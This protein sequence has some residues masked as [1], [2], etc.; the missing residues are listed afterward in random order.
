VESLAA[1]GDER[2]ASGWALFTFGDFRLIDPQKLRLVLPNRKVE[3]LLAVLAL[4]RKYGIERDAAAEIVWPGRPRENQRA[5]LRQALSQVRRV[6][7]EDAVEASRSHLRLANSFSLTCDYESPAFRSA[8]AFM[9]GHEGDWFED[10]RREA[11][12][13][14]DCVEAAPS[15]VMGNFMDS[16]GM[17]AEMDPRGMF[18]FMRA[19]PSMSRGV[20][21]SAL[22]RLLFGRLVGEDYDG[23]RDYWFG[24][25]TDDLNASGALLRSAMRKA[26][27]VS[28]Y[29]LASEA[30]LELGRVYSRTGNLERA[31]K[32]CG[33]AETVAELAKTRTAR[34]N[35]LRLRGTHLIN[36]TDSEQG[37]RLLERSEELTDDL[38]GRTHLRSV[39]SFMLASVG[40]LRQAEDL[41]AA[42][43]KMEAKLGHGSTAI[44]VGLTHSLL[45]VAG[46]SP[47][48]AVSGL[49]AIVRRSYEAEIT[50]TGVYA[51]E[52]LAN[53]FNISGDKALAR[54]RL[55]SA[56]QHRSKA[57]MILT[58]V[59]AKRLFYLR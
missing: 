51:E 14:S 49:E 42:P 22:R 21:Y 40:Q 46:G 16:L 56:R 31:E 13:D 36:W 11:D 43:A 54:N 37:L 5:S 10:I 27:S 17:L 1:I 39:R 24:T 50:Q 32:I 53:I 41:I 55:D 8:G 19:N 6:V 15:S 20:P 38:V 57:N 47:E 35:A 9:P 33:I 2:N 52:M 4:H 12:T 30:A 26:K 44:L 58:P 7:G 28:D 23:W 48:D 18:A 59:E 34:A 29:E 45:I 25:I 3:A